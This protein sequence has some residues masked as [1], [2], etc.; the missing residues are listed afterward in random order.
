MFVP[1]ARLP[2]VPPRGG[3]RGGSTRDGGVCISQPP[4]QP[5]LLRASRGSASRAQ[6]DGKREGVFTQ[7]AG[8]SAVAIATPE[9]QFIVGEEVHF[10]GVQLSNASIKHG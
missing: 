1:A 5:R 8:R 6:W 4:A 7:L 3:K 10:W 2:P 9:G